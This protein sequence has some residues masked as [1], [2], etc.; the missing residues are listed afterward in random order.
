[1]T[2]IVF[3]DGVLAAD[4]AVFDRGCYCGQ[5]EKIHRAPNGS[6]FGAAGALGDLVRFKD[7]MMAGEPEDKRPEFRDDDSEAIVIRPD[8][9]VHWFGT[10]DY[11]EIVGDFHAIGSGFRVAMGAFAAGATAEQA[12]EIAADIDSHTRRPIKVLKLE[13]HP[14]VAL[15]AS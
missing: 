13:L 15:V 3:R 10:R 7:W 11:A 2:T 5:A 12:I 8:G 4:T 14:A 1:M 9:T 6:L